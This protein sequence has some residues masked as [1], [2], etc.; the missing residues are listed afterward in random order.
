MFQNNDEDNCEFE[1]KSYQQIDY[2][3]NHDL[4]QFDNL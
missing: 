4:N 1:G 3:D 2:S